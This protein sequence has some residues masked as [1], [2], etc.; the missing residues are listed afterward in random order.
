MTKTA[1]IMNKVKTRQHLRQLS[2]QSPFGA[3][4]T[5]AVQDLGTINAGHIRMID[6]IMNESA[7]K[8]RLQ[9]LAANEFADPPAT[10]LPDLVAA[11]TIYIGAVDAELRD[12]LIYPA[13][14]TWI[15]AGL[16]NEPQ[17]SHLFELASDDNHLFYRLGEPES[18]SVYTRTF[19]LLLFPLILGRHR[20]KPFLSAHQIHTAKARVFNYLEQEQDRRGYVPG[21]GWAHAVAHAADVLDDLALCL[22][23]GAEDL[24]DILR[25]AAA[26]LTEP[27]FVY[28]HDEPERM[29]IAVFAVLS[30]QVLS[31]AE[32]KGWLEGVAA[33][34]DQ[35]EVMLERFY[36]RMNLKQFITSLY[37]RLSRPANLERITPEWR[38]FLQSACEE[39]LTSL[40]PY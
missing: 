1:N 35:Y 11:M 4:I 18:H 6:T 33:A 10:E 24:R 15:E 39:A 31:E 21:N 12:A 19:S 29:S 26:T 37:F 36:C 3:K 40:S 8:N 27:R 25:L 20:E 9:Q 28:T 23:L 34:P 14:A 22:E 38:N 5:R 7:L 16:L 32:V 30:R 13:F 17:L 2:L